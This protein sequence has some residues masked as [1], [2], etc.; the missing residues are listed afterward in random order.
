[1]NVTTRPGFIPRVK[2][3]EPRFSSWGRGG[4]LWGGPGSFGAGTAS[5]AAVIVPQGAGSGPAS[6]RT[7]NPLQTPKTGFPDRTK[8]TRSFESLD[9]NR[10]AKIVPART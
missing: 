6:T 1:M 8:A 7:W 10:A 9:R 4:R 3:Q 5:G 2:A